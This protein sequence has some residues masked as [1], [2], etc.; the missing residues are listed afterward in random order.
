MRRIALTAALLALTLAACGGDD[1]ASPT[2]TSAT[3]EP[4]PSRA[5]VSAQAAFAGQ[6]PRVVLVQVASS[7]A[8]PLEEVRYVLEES[9]EQ[10][11]V[12]VTAATPTQRCTGE[13]ELGN[14]EVVL[15]R[16]LGN[17]EIVDGPS[18]DVLQVATGDAPG[19][20]V[21]TIEAGRG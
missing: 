13:P 9:P 21:P 12:E 15:E 19:P 6:D 1:T 8:C 16:P 2:T 3:P 11:S 17:R 18:G 7:G 10:V 5:Q 4:T 20:A 14:V